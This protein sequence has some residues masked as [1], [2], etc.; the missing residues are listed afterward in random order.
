MRTAA[1]IKSCSTGWIHADCLIQI[2]EGFP[3]SR[4]IGVPRQSPDKERCQHTGLLLKHFCTRFL[5]IFPFAVAPILY[6]ELDE[7]RFGCG[8]IYL[9]CPPIINHGLIALL[10]VRPAKASAGQIAS[11]RQGVQFDCLRVIQH[12]L[13]LLTSLLI[14][15]PP[16]KEGLGHLGIPVDDLC[17]ILNGAVRI[18]ALGIKAAAQKI[19]AGQTRI[20][21]DGFVEIGKGQILFRFVKEPKAPHQIQIR[22]IRITSDRSTKI[23]NGKG[24]L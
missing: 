13:V 15:L 10:F 17:K 24:G 1:K 5:Q 7:K 11:R 19:G 9:K 18:I 16:G 2:E 3:V 6:K 4:N 14:N 21:F 8:D 23:Y 20:Q 12:G 22:D